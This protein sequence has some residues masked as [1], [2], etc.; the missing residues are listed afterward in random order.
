[1]PIGETFQRDETHG[2][3]FRPVKL[4]QV[5]QTHHFDLRF[6][7]IHTR[8]RLI[9]ELVFLGIMKPLTGSIELFADVFHHA[10]FSMHTHLTIVLPTAFVSHRAIRILPRD[11]IMIAAP[12]SDM[13]RM[14]EAADGIFP[15]CRTFLGESIRRIALICC[16]DFRSIKVR[17]ARHA[18]T[19]TI[20]E[21]LIDRQSGGCFSNILPFGLNLPFQGKTCTTTDHRLTLMHGLIGDWKFFRT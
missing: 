4:N 15:A 7:Q 3:I 17:I 8:F 21:Q 5:R 13:H 11:A 20:D 1:M 12:A 2:R 19:H 10:K 14:N 18:L 9:I 6:R 16:R